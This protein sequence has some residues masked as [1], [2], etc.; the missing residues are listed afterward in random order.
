MS[1]ASYGC[2]VVGREGVLLNV[3]GLLRKIAKDLQ[4][5]GRRVS[6]CQE[7]FGDTPLREQTRDWDERL[8]LTFL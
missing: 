3:I 4:S 6:R 7:L 1:G 2:R 8:K 5:R